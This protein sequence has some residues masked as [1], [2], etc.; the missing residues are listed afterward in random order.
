MFA[1]IALLYM[2]KHG[3]RTLVILSAIALSVAVMVFIDA[4]MVGLRESFF[5]GLFQD[6]GHLQVH[7]EG[8]EDRLDP[9]AIDYA[10]SDPDAVLARLSEDRR[11]RVA[12]KVL[13]FGALLINAEKHLPIGGVGVREGTAYYGRVVRGMRQGSLP[14]DGQGIT[15]ST[16]VAQLLDLRFG[17]PVIALVQDS[18]GSAFYMEY[19]VV[20]LFDTGSNQFDT[21]HF[22]LLHDAAQELLYL[23]DAT[24]EV[25]ANLHE[26]DDAGAVAETVA[27]FLRQRS[28]EAQTWRELQGSFIVAFELFDI[29]VIFIDVVVVVVTATVIINTILMNVFERTGEIGTLRAIGLKRRQQLAM[30]VTEGALEGAA[31]AALGLLVGIP[32]TL[33]AQ[34]AGVPVGQFSESFGL[35]RVV[36]PSLTV[37][38]V[39]RSFGGGLL[40]ALVGSGYASMVSGRRPIVRM[41]TEA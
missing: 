34:H 6:T 3:K 11:V 32:I 13:P 41:I 5:R 7:E 39:A 20:G 8:Y 33:L 37:I 24:V 38:T 15:V 16:K 12:E 18:Q 27:P 22:F 10:I 9:Y 2:R 40:I 4:M 25:R 21:S 14:T 17:D 31:G 30:I 19:T 26:P 36:Y 29:F 1:K 28:L 35:S 23:G